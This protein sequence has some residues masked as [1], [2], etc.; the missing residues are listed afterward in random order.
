MSKTYPITKTTDHKIAII[1]R[2]IAGLPLV[3]FG[4]LHFVKPAGF[5]N[6]LIASG[7]PLVE[8]NVYAAPVAE[9]IGGVLLLFGFYAR[10]GGV[11]GMATMLVAIYTTVVL[12][13]MTVETLPGGLTEVPQVPPLL[14]PV[15]ATIASL[16][17]IILGG[18]TWSL[19]WRNQSSQEKANR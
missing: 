3:G 15:M 8:L 2:I 16:V 5:Q 10:V 18:G 12:S 9:V 13:G 1:S 14:L 4:V 11:F 6:I 7:I 19:D 17:V